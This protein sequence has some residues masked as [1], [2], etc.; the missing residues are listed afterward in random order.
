MDHG[1]DSVQKA[2]PATLAAGGAAGPPPSV[3]LLTYDVLHPIPSHTLWLS[4]TE[5][6]EEK[7]YR[8]LYTLS[9][10]PW[11]QRDTCT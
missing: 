7:D 11:A 5:N 8:G 4:S 3:C 9:F 1:V 6:V 2:S 10:P